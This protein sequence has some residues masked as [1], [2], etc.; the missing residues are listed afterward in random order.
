MDLIKNNGGKVG[1]FFMVFRIA[2][3]GSRQT[4]P[5]VDCLPI[6]GKNNTL[7]K[8]DLALNKL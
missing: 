1:D 4:P 3:A 6:L 2:I 7:R 5:I 8:I